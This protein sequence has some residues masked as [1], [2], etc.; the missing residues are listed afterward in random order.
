MGHSSIYF[1]SEKMSI[2]CPQ[3]WVQFRIY[4]LTVSAVFFPH[5]QTTIY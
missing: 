4:T 2:G 5:Y 3:P 1:D